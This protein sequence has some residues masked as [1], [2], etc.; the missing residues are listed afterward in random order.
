[1]HKKLQ[2]ALLVLTYLPLVASEL[3]FK[4]GTVTALGH[5]SL[6]VLPDAATIGFT[7][8]IIETELGGISDKAVRVSSEFNAKLAKLGIDFPLVHRGPG[9]VYGQLNYD[10]QRLEYTLTLSFDCAVEDLS[11]MDKVLE[12]IETQKFAS[13]DVRVSVTDVTYTLKDITPYI[14]Q[15]RE[16]ALDQAGKQAKELAVSYGFSLGEL[17]ACSE[18]PAITGYSYSPYSIWDFTAEDRGGKSELPRVMVS[19][20]LSATYEFRQE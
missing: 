12:L 2:I 10:A 20:D 4:D 17:T 1:M 11:L 3:S 16:S 7:L 14:P 9:S 5:S 8:E 15:L 19:F 6:L 18:T 13:A